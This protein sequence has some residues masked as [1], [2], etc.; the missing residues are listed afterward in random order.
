MGFADPCKGWDSKV[1]RMY[2]MSAWGGGGVGS[3]M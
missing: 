3:M 2:R 1:L